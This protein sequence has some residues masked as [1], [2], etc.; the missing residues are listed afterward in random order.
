M[1]AVAV[2]AL[3]AL[4][5]EDR[6]ARLFFAMLAAVDLAMHGAAARGVAAVTKLRALGVCHAFAA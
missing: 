3:A 5:S 2:T 1:R 4:T 6:A